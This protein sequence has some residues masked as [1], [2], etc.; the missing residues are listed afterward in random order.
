M[1]GPLHRESHAL[2]ALQRSLV[3]MPL[4][5]L[6]RLWK[7]DTCYTL[8][9]ATIAPN[10]SSLGR[11]S[12]DLAVRCAERSGKRTLF[13]EAPRRNA[14]DGCQATASVAGLELEERAWNCLSDALDA[15]G[16]NFRKAMAE[17]AEFPRL[18]HDYGLIVVNL[19]DIASQSIARVGKLCDGIVLLFEPIPG[20]LPEWKRQMRDAT[21]Q[22][23]SHQAEG[24]CMVGVWLAN[25]SSATLD[26]NMPGYMRS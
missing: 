8:G 18:K 24:L 19:G 1:V 12:R 21:L 25:A 5:G 2:N 26:A 16:M 23:R 3:S 15:R 22:I 20:G 14:G 7:R 10:E 6:T 17:L 13:L 11:C 9:V 4:D